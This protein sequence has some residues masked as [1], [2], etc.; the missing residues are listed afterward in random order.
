MIFSPAEKSFFFLST[1]FD[2]MRLD[3]LSAQMQRRKLGQ[4]G[5]DIADREKDHKFGDVHAADL[6]KQGPIA[7]VV[8]E[9]RK[10]IFVLGEDVGAKV[11]RIGGQHVSAHDF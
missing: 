6:R 3:R 4:N 11:A 9:Y 2:P 8:R 5:G 1:Y 7:D 10:G